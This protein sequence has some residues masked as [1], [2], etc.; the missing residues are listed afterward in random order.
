M[1]KIVMRQPSETITLETAFREF[2]VS[3]S[4]KGVKEKTIKTYFSHFKGISKHLNINL[5]FSELKRQDLEGMIVSMRESGLAHN[6]ISSYI[7]VMKTFL[8]W[9]AN[10]GYT[11][12]TLPN[13]K[14]QETV[15][16]VYSDEELQRLLKRPSAGCNFCEYRNW[17]IV[18][19][20]LNSGCRAST[21]RNIQIRDVSL[22]AQQVLFR[23]TKSGKIQTIPLCTKMVTILRAYMPIRG[24]E[25]MDF[26]F[27]DDYGQQLTENALRLA[28]ARY[29]TRRGVQKTSIHLFRHTF[30][31][32]YLVDCGGDAFTLQRLLGHSTLKMT[33]H[34]CTIYDKDIAKNFDR[35]SPLAQFSNAK[36]KITMRK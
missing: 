31:R 18:N 21:V 13:Y 3:Q 30:A 36:E 10:N 14:Q 5:T 20:F 22:S 2:V 19:F 17:V 11:A 9:C 26:L 8:A 16:E 32:K 25:E 34:Y 1:G 33:K 24:G 27:C 35:L 7:R 12:L 4:A 23:H 29:N 6:S 28:I 15:K